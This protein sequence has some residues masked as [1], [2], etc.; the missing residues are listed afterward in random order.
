MF[1]SFDRSQ[2]RD[3]SL[4]SVEEMSDNFL[5][6]SRRSLSPYQVFPGASADCKMYGRTTAKHSIH[7]RRKLLSDVTAKGK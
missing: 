1:D 7:R 5:R 6:L 2:W 3:T 4:S